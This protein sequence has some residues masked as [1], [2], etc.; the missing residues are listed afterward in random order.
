MKSHRRE[1][2]FEREREREKE[3]ETEESEIQERKKDRKNDFERE[4]ETE[5]PS[6]SDARTSL[7]HEPYA[8]ESPT[9]ALKACKLH[10]LS[11]NT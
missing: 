3:R 11:L 4:G 8:T 7:R 5:M 6:K 1:N 2:D 9:K 10:S